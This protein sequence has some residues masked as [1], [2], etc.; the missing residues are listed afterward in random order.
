MGHTL[1]GV[2][3]KLAADPTYRAEFEKAFGPGPISFDMVGKAIASFERTV[4]SA[5]SP[6][7][8][9]FYGGRRLLSV[10]RPGAAWRSF[11]IPKKAIARPVMFW[12][13]SLITSFTTSVWE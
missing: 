10:R 9:Y 12:A 7:D 11:V 2:E 3:E 13:F 5:N 8:R 1:D 6:F 4:I